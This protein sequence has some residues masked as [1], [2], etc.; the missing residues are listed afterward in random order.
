MSHPLPEG[1]ERS[2]Q[3][4]EYID[5][6][7]G[8]YFRAICLENAG[9]AVPQHAHDHDHVTLIASGKARLWIEGVWVED[10]HS[11]KVI[12]IE[13]GR[14]HVFQALEPM[15]RLVCVHNLNGEPYRVAKES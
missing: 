8:L 2:E 12:E 7:C 10:I 1:V 9:D 11:F 6:V 3:A 5:D 14:K 4:V 15:T 13:A